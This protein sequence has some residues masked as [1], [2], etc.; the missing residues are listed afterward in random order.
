MTE[1]PEQPNRGVCIECGEQNRCKEY[2]GN[3]RGILLP[4]TKQ[5]WLERFSN[6]F[7]TIGHHYLLNSDNKEV[8]EVLAS[9]LALFIQ[10]EIAKA[11]EEERQEI[12]KEL[13]EIEKV[14]WDKEIHCS[15]LS[16]AIFK[17]KCDCDDE[18]GRCKQACM[19]DTGSPPNIGE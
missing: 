16:Y 17:M 5:G 2:C 13:E 19:T 18:C 1:Q 12:I 4:A 3:V 11:R 6:Q 15:C 8:G 14:K 7:L 10:Q 9:D